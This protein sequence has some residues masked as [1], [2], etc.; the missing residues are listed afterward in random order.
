MDQSKSAGTPDPFAQQWHSQDHV[1]SKGM[2]SVQQLPADVFMLQAATQMQNPGQEFVMDDSMSVHMGNHMSY[3]Q[4]HQHHAH[5]QHNGGRHPLPAEQLAQN[6]SFNEG[7]SQMAD[8]QM[9]DA[10]DDDSMAAIVGAPKPNASRSSANNELEMRQL[11]G[12]NRHRKLQEVAGELHGDER[13]PNS[14]RTRQ[15]FAMLW[16]ALQPDLSA[17]CSYRQDQPSLLQWEG[18]RPPWQGIRQLCLPL[19][20]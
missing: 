4:P 14:E 8:S 11:F 16:Y 7:D 9:V 5:Q 3:Q 12:A 15:V 2:G 19:C 18:L 6:A 20:Y 17:R 13:G 1:N 10:D